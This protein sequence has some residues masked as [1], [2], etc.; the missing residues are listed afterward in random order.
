M[1]AM[2]QRRATDIEGAARRDF[3]P[4]TDCLGLRQGDTPEKKK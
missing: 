2:S 3:I 4:A 1:E